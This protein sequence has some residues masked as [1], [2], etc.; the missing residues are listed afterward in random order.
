MLSILAARQLN[1]TLLGPALDANASEDEK[2]QSVLGA[3]QAAQYLRENVLQGVRREDHKD[4]YGKS[5]AELSFSYHSI[6]ILLLI[7]T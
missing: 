6:Y 4:T 1:R 3:N 2:R 7:L 5:S